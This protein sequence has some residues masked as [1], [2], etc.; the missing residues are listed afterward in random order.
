MTTVPTQNAPSI[1]PTP[2]GDVTMSETTTYWRSLGELENTPEFQDALQREFPEGI[3]EAP[4][5]VSRRGFLSAVAA[6]VALAGLTSCRKPVTKILPFNKS[7]EGYKAG[8]PSFYA[9]TLTRNGFGIGVVVKSSD[10]RPTK[11]EGNAAHPSSLGGSDLQLQAELLQL[12]DP[13]RS[14]HPCSAAMRAEAAKK[15]A[16]GGDGHAHDAH[17]DHGHGPSKADDD[18]VW[19]AFRVWLAGDHRPARVTDDDDNATTLVAQ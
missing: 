9:T 3:T 12:Y 15:H 4:D 16:A 14:R 6:S 11:I 8:L 18:A 1:A 19:S 10:G 7:P 17:G 2:T 5:A 13:N